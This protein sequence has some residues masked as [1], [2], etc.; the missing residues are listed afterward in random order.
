MDALDVADRVHVAPVGY[1]NDRI[2]LPAL[3]LSADRVV[4]LA[5]EDETDHPSFL[6]AVR[7]RLD[8]RGLPH[9][10]VDCDIFD[11]Y[12]C[13]GTVGS[14]VAGFADEEVFVNLASG[15][16]ITAIGGMIACMAT[17]A[18]PYYVRAERYGPMTDGAVAEGVR[19]IVE[20]PTYPMDHPDP[21]QVATLRHLAEHGPATK[22]QLIRF[23][24]EV[25]LPALAEHETANRK[26][27]YRRLDAR[28]LNPL[29]DFGYVELDRRGRSTSVS[30]TD[31]GRDALRAFAYLA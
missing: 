15:T 22:K 27:K 21:Q 23:A 7:D 2:V 28:V 26:G 5:Y 4:M 8:D 10:T 20:L 31:A 16:K 3:E 17:G 25:G 24:E 19:E 9:E 1:E 14:V 13:I 12:D 18:T 11:F 29:V 6:P 30:V